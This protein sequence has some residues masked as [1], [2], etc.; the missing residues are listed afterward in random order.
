V[1]RGWFRK[2]VGGEAVPNIYCTEDAPDADFDAVDPAHA[3]DDFAIFRAEVEVCRKVASGLDLD[4]L[5]RHQRRDR[6]IDLRW[7]YVHMIEEYARHNG[8]AD[9]IRERIDGTIGD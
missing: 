2:F 8:H 6:D 5:T 7:V 1:E 9:L 3:A 4:H